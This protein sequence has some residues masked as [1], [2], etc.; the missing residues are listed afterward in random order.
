[1][2]DQP[3]FPGTVFA[4]IFCLV[5][6]AITGIASWI[7]L[8][9]LTIPKRLTL[10]A[11]ALGVLFNLV[12]GAL[13]GFQGSEHGVWLLGP[14]GVLLSMT[15]GLLF[16]GAGF[17]V[18]FGLFFLMW[19]LGT[20]GGGD[21]KLFAAL[22]AWLGPTLSIIVLAGTLVFVV[23]LSI[24]RLA[25]T[26]FRTGMRS[27]TRDYT[28]AGAARTGKKAGKQGGAGSR[29]T[30]ERLMAYSLPVALSTACILL[31]VFRVEL[32]L[33]L[34][35]NRSAVKQVRLNQP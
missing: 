4:W 25:G 27:A 17:L 33:P 12:R 20:C 29:R 13:I 21:V 34:P 26:V 14:R 15:D 9:T 2:F 7:D 30:R 6:L 18:G 1:M 32:Q 11:L 28:M 19:F 31:W 8:R 5:L 35:E 16:S 10:G 23:L 3:F 24:L 22:G